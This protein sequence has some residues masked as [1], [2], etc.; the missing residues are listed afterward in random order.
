MK[1]PQWIYPE[2]IYGRS[3]LSNEMFTYLFDFPRPPTRLSVDLMKARMVA[4]YWG[5]E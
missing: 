5:L 1:E 4:V 2:Y 3:R